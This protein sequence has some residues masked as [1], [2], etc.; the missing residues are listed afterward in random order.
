M[1]YI[2]GKKIPW[3]QGLTVKE[4]LITLND[5]YPYA[6]VRINDKH[7]SRPDFETYLIPDHAEIFPLPLISGG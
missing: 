4:V 6:V 2:K 5:P 3:H 1:I 7:I